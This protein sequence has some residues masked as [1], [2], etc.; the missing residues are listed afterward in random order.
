MGQDT[1]CIR[2]GF[3]RHSSLVQNLTCVGTCIQCTYNVHVHVCVC[4]CLC[5]CVCVWGG[6]GG[7]GGGG[8]VCVVSVCVSAHQ[9]ISHTTCAHIHTHTQ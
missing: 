6:G 5:V 8:I 9:G 4:V 2:I 7:G 1:N 3:Q